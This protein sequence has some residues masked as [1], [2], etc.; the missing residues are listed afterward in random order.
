LL[1]CVPAVRRANKNTGKK[2]ETIAGKL[3][4]NALA[5]EGARM[6]AEMTNQDLV[7]LFG[8]DLAELLGVVIKTT[9]EQAQEADLSDDARKRA[10]ETAR[11]VLSSSGFK[12]LPTHITGAAITLVA[13]ALLAASEQFNVSC[14]LLAAACCLL[15]RAACCCVLR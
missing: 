1:A 3:H 7:A 8:D 10:I 15:L 11:H 5:G 13:K 14:V 12:Q 4:A 2:L 9:V 6:R